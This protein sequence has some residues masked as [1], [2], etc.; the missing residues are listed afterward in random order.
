MPVLTAIPR[1]QYVFGTMSPK[2]TLRKVIEIS[3]MEFRRLACSSSWNLCAKKRKN[4][5]LVFQF[6]GPTEIY[7][8]KIFSMRV[9]N[10]RLVVFSF[11]RCKHI[12]PRSTIDDTTSPHHGRIVNVVWTEKLLNRIHTQN[13]VLCFSQPQWRLEHKRHK[14]YHRKFIVS[15]TPPQQNAELFS[16]FK[17]C[18]ISQIYCTC[19][20]WSFWSMIFSII[21]ESFAL[22]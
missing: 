18:R 5:N 12:S 2:P 16:R 6:A 21:V 10:F 9:W 11:S 1:P 15:L 22:Q 7:G 13:R 19:A 3:H 20:R 14:S 17:M 8:R 4:E